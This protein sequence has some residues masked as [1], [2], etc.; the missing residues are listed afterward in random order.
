RQVLL[1][2][3]LNALDATPMGGTVRI[4]TARIDA[5]DEFAGGARVLVEDSGSGLSAEAEARLFTPFF[6]TKSRG[7]GLGLAV[8]RSIVEEHRGKIDIRNRPEGG[9]RAQVLFPPIAP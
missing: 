9:T 4:A 7:T 1:N 2:L 3:L 6:S 8:S 5:P